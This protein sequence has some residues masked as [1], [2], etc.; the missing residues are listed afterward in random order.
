MAAERR[1]RM[2][3]VAASDSDWADFRQSVWPRSIAARLGELVERDVA[4][5]RSKRLREGTLDDGQLLDALERARELHADLSAI[6]ARLER[7][8]DRQA[9]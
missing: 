5:W 2:A 4:R 3:R 1:E 8:L 9:R 7:R 6:V